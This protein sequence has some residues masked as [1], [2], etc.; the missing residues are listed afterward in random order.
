MNNIVNMKNNCSRKYRCL[1]QPCL[2]HVLSKMQCGLIIIGKDG[3]SKIYVLKPSAIPKN[4]KIPISTVNTCVYVANEITFLQS[5]PCK[6]GNGFKASEDLKASSFMKFHYQHTK[7]NVRLVFRVLIAYKNSLFF[8]Q[9]V[10]IMTR[11]FISGCQKS[12][13]RLTMPVIYNPSQ[14]YSPNTTCSQT[15]TQDDYRHRQIVG[16]KS[17]AKV[18][19]CRLQHR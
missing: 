17:H 18:L 4:Q 6:F 11:L 19:K 2:L 14:N 15:Q 1:P 10:V 5:T 16:H 3:K 7:K 13:F 8:S 12:K 9:T